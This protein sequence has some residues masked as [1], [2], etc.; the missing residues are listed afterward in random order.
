MRSAGRFARF[1]LP[2]ILILGLA[3]AVTAWYARRTYYVDFNQS[4]QVTVYQGRPGGLL[5]WD[6][7]VIRRTT[8]TKA[9]LPE[10]ARVDVEDRKEF[11]DKGAAISFVGR[12][13]ARATA[14]TSTTTTTTT[15][16]PLVPVPST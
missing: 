2:I 1:I 10:D 3:V 11:A 6:P 4:G 13:E 12:V 7:T 15:T 14:A 9:D 8:L 5:F 16:N